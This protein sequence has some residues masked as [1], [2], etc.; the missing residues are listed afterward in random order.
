MTAEAVL[1]AIQYAILG[2]FALLN[3]LYSLFGYLGLRAV[4][5]QARTRSETALLDLLQRDVHTPVSILV[6]AYN[7]QA[8]IVASVRALLS[9]RHPQFEVIVVSD[10]STDATLERMTEAFGLVEVPLVYRHALPTQPITRLMRSLRHHNLL[11][12]EKVNGGKADALNAALDLSEYPLVCA[13][14]ADS[15]LDADALLR[16]SRIFTE[17]D[18]VAGVGGSVRPLN[19]AT[20]RDGRVVELRTPSRWVE[21]F[22]VLEYARAF[23]TGRAGWSHIGALLI[24]SG[25]FGLFRREAIVG[26][27]GYATDTVGEDME[28]VVRLHRRSVEDGR[29]ARVVWTPDPVCWT[30]TPSDL[31]TLRRQRNRW[32]R[33]LWE[34][35]WRHRD[36]LGRARHRRVGLIGLPYFWLF[37]GLSPLV[38]VAG[39]VTLAV[40][41][42]MGVLNPAM[43]AT[44]FV[45]AV[46]YGALLSQIAISIE[47]LLVARYP[48]LRDRLVLLAASV[49][50][51]GGYHQ[52][53][54]FER[55]VAMTQIR[56]RR[57]TW[58]ARRRRGIEPA[59]VV[60]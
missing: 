1:D 20:L 35:L 49:L 7:E 46:A 53:L 45:L 5:L 55:L 59:T 25:A 26:A 37:E 57:G 36:M 30:E 41:W 15:L 14:D 33:G 24:I 11:V 22:Q 40:A 48:R 27:G 44:F 50:E 47:T 52:L 18:T 31:G 42:A 32:Q 9:L 51:F 19:G 12:A 13:V 4:I 34:T 8:S 39:Y 28:L 21:R 56:R 16:A 23:F 10:G 17:D 38:E 29:R 58:G 6:P 54:A 43:A 60:S 2:Y 3:G